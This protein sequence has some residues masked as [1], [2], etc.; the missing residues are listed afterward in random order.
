MHHDNDRSRWELDQKLKQLTAR[1][2][3]LEAAIIDNYS[4]E[5]LRELNILDHH[6]EVTR[7]RVT[8]QWVKPDIEEY[9][10]LK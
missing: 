9:Q 6:I 3:E 8:G 4:E 2:D 7:Q 5:K 1:R 10:I